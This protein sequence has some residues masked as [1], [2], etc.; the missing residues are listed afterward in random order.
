MENT[1]SKQNILNA[2]I[3]LFSKSGFSNV[4]IREI[5]TAAGIK[6]ASLYYHFPNKQSIY[7][8]A[9]AYSF[10]NK[11]VAFT[12]VL[13]SNN[14]ALERLKLFIYKFTELMSNDEDF[15][16]LLQREMLDGDDKRLKYI[17]DK[18]FKEQFGAI[19]QLMKLVFPEYDPHMMTISISSLILHHL[20]TAPIRKFLP[21]HKPEHDQP[22][23]IA[24]HVYLL[25]T[26]ENMS[27][28][29]EKSST[30]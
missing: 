17:A 25:L 18:V 11:A 7:L 2:A 22:D 15:R 3:R 24:R 30:K 19:G 10:S 8:E 20:E 16:R 28:D 13:E 29:Y 14:S 21:G 1:H 4:S 9:I 27:D 26:K 6:S 5:A 23:Y 12:G